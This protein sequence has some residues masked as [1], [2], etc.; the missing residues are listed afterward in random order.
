MYRTNAL[1]GFLLLVLGVCSFFSLSCT[2]TNRTVIDEAAAIRIAN[3]VVDTAVDEDEQLRGN[4]A[5]NLHS[6]GYILLS[7]ETV[8]YLHQIPFIDGTMLNYLQ[9]IFASA[10]GNDHLEETVVSELDGI[11]AGIYDN[12]LYY[13]DRSNDW[14]I[15]VLD[16]ETF[17]TVVLSTRPVDALQVF[18]G[19]LYYSYQDQSGLYCAAISGSWTEKLITNVGGKLLSVSRTE[20]L[21]YGECSSN[22]SLKLVSL[23]DGSVK[24]TFEGHS[25]EK[26]QKVGSWIFF[27]EEE[28]LWRL[29]SETNILEQAVMM[30]TVGDYAIGHGKLVVA[31]T[32]GGVS[33]GKIDGTGMNLL[34]RDFAVDLAITNQYVFYKNSLD[35]HN[36]YAI[37]TDQSKRTIVQGDT[38][39]EYGQAIRMLNEA[40]SASVKMYHGAFLQE[41]LKLETSTK[42]YNQTLKSGVLFAEFLQ[43]E[44]EPVL[45]W[46]GEQQPSFQSSVGTIV[47]VEYEI[48][49]LG[50]YSDGGEARRLDTVLTVFSP[51][52]LIPL[53]SVVVEG[54]PPSPIKYGE[55]DR[56]GLPRSWLQAALDLVENYLR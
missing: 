35:E 19:K 5:S 48:T 34:T 39:L 38:K 25:F 16:L 33:I 2:S 50:H 17:E 14:N 20:A 8:Y 55:G 47:T 4:S 10:I 40:E 28:K 7:N 1:R 22:R 42:S 15:T 23:E 37:D 21:V 26:A 54:K 43:S 45:Y 32:N 12:R 44:Q 49:S 11:M 6:G 51:D 9:T 3:Y 53:F 46:I 52:S 27:I 24:A 41:A 30:D 31:D 56:L 13:I 18:D 36:I 29:S